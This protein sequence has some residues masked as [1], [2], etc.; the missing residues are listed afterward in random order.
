MIKS[1]LTAV[2]VVN[3]IFVSSSFAGDLET[4]LIQAAFDGNLPN[5]Y[6]LLKKGASANAQGYS[7]M[8]PLMFA[9]QNGHLKV[10]NVLIENG[11]DINAQDK[12]GLKALDYAQRLNQYDVVEVLKVKTIITTEQDVKVKT[13]ITAEQ[14]VKAKVTNISEQDAK[15]CKFWSDFA[16]NIMTLRQDGKPISL[17]MKIIDGSGRSNG[18][19]LVLENITHQAF[20]ERITFGTQSKRYVVAKFR[21]QISTRCFDL[22]NN[23]NKN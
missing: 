20:N 19:K 8:T 2:I 13:M 9:A 18:E 5:V 6:F 12:H 17:L 22:V 15:M 23:L 16:E 1:I 3:F 7:N 4:E 14:D 11:A 10:V 21:E